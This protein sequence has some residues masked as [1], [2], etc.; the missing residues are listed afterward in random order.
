MEFETKVWVV[1]WEIAKVG[2]IESRCYSKRFYT[3]ESA[4]KCARQISR[5]IDISPCIEEMRN[6]DG[7]EYRNKMADFIETLI[8][9]CAFFSNASDIPYSFDPKDYKVPFNSLGYKKTDFSN[10]KDFVI[11]KTKYGGIVFKYG[12]G[13][14]YTIKTDVKYLTEGGSCNINST[15]N[16]KFYCANTDELN[17]GQIS[18]LTL[19]LKRSLQ[20][21]K[22]R[23]SVKIL[24]VL[25]QSNEPL[26]QTEIMKLTR[27]NDRK[28]V[29]RNVKK[30][31]E[32]GYDIR[33]DDDLKYYI[34]K[35]SEVLTLKDIALIRESIELNTQI[36]LEEKERIIA[37]LSK[38]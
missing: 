32:A 16:F 38:I 23:H 24:E 37:L 13:A 30:L 17:D 1:D 25:R 7:F 27:I 8:T 36:P 34:P 9:N 28:T 18:N 29:W 3:F 20:K 11:D 4:L 12:H 31:R 14:E 5:E 10:G 6:V 33:R 2:E 15:F 35:T 26:T 21:N 22:V 19:S